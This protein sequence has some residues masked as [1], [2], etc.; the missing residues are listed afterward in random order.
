MKPSRYLVQ[1]KARGSGCVH[2][3]SP[4]TAQADDRPVGAGYDTGRTKR[5]REDVNHNFRCDFF[6]WDSANSR[7]AGTSVEGG[8]S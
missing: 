1:I 4:N 6:L 2:C 3:M 5:P 7:K 8:G